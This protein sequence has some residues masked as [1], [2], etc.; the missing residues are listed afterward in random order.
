MLSSDPALLV[1]EMEAAGKK[2]TLHCGSCSE[3]HVDKAWL[4]P[5][6]SDEKSHLGFPLSFESHY[7][8]LSVTT[9]QHAWNI[10]AV[11]RVP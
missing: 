7:P 1:S 4:T 9:C 8:F 2:E 10:P 3:L 5:R 6:F 11:S